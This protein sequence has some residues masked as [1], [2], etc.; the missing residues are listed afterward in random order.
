MTKNEIEKMMKRVQTDSDKRMEKMMKRQTGALLE[1]FQHR[2]SAVAEQ[3]LSLNAKID[4]VQAE[5]DNVAYD[6]KDIKSKMTN[7]E[8]TMNVSFERKAEKKLF[9]ELD[10]RVR[11]LEKK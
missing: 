6:V 3:H 1:E 2:V 5:I 4:R 7:V 9:V 11:A 8:Y 10:N